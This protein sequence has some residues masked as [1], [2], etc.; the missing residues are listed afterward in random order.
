MASIS[1]TIF[2]IILA[3]LTDSLPNDRYNTVD[4]MF[5]SALRRKSS[6]R[7]TPTPRSKE[8]RV[9]VFQQFV[10]SMSDQQLVTGTA[11]IVALNMIRWGVMGLDTELSGFTYSM[12]VILAYFSCITHLASI[13]V[14]RNYM[15]LH[16]TPRNIRLAIMAI[17]IGVL[18]YNLLEIQNFDLSSTLSCALAENPF[19]NLQAGLQGSLHEIS[20]ALLLYAA[21]V[22]GVILIGYVRRGLELFSKTYRVDHSSW[23]CELLSLALDRRQMNTAQF[24]EM[25]DRRRFS[26]CLRISRGSRAAIILSIH[27]EL[28]HSFM[29]EMIWILFYYFFGL[30]Q[31][32]Y[33]LAVATNDWGVSLTNAISWRPGFGQLLPLLLLLLPILNAVDAYFGKRMPDPTAPNLQHDKSTH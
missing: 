7:A 16:H 15:D 22:V 32:I 1:F 20:V 5:L 28:A 3:Y 9:A 8:R 17:S 12:A 24:Q 23:V 11:L 14:L 33:T 29:W 31:F 18:L 25:T 19:G 13:S 10:R 21:S 30:A 27:A 4:I 2:L 6:S 26:R